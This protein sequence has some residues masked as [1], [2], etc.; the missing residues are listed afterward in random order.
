MCAHCFA[1]FSVS[2]FYACNLFRFSDRISSSPETVTWNYGS[3]DFCANFRNQSYFLKMICISVTLVG[4]C[5]H[6]C[7]NFNKY[8]IFAPC[9]RDTFILFA[10]RFRQVWR[11]FPLF[12]MPK[13]QTIFYAYYKFYV[14]F[15]IAYNKHKQIP[16]NVTRRKPPRM[17]LCFSLSL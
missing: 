15:Y 16:A 9:V 13:F 3:D 6:S 17:F 8:L 2:K 1:S 10:N 11:I 7:Q 14:Y 5:F 4:I 12:R